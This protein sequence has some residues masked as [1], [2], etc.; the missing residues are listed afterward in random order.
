[1]NMCHGST[2]KGHITQT[3]DDRESFL[4]EAKQGNSINKGPEVITSRIR[5]RRD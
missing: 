1:M 4:E 5:L 2:D 3:R